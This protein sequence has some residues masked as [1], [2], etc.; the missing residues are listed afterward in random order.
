MRAP[1]V[2]ARWARPCPRRS[3]AT[4][5][6]I[7]AT[8]TPSSRAPTRAVGVKQAWEAPEGGGTTAA[9]AKRAWAAAKRFIDAVRGPGSHT[10]ELASTSMSSDTAGKES[11]QDAAVRTTHRGRAVVPDVRTEI[12]SPAAYADRTASTGSAAPRTS[13]GS[14]VMA[15]SLRTLPRSRGGVVVEV[16][17]EEGPLLRRDATWAL[18]GEVERHEHGAAGDGEPTVVEEL[19]VAGEGRR[20]DARHPDLDLQRLRVVD[21]GQLVGDLV[22]MDHQATA[23][24]G[25]LVVGRVLEEQVDPG[26]LQVAEEGHVVDVLVGVHVR[27]AHGDVHRVPHGRHPAVRLPGAPKAPGSRRI[28]RARACGTWRGAAAPPRHRAARPCS[29][30]SRRSCPRTR[31]TGTHPRRRGCGLRRGRGTTGR[32]SRRRRNR[33]TPTARPRGWSGSRRRGRW[34][35]RPAAAG[36]RPA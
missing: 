4:T 21:D 27:P 26:H 23:Q 14:D 15:P 10:R 5:R 9:P 17:L 20:P 35:A 1:A 28:S 32:G 36:C 34:W 22:R 25:A 3:P 16:A 2:A 30:R 31:T 6:G 18:E 12:R 19:V 11:T 8:S 29:S 33:G 7:P 24:P 13:T